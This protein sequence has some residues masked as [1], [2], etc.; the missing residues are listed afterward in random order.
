MHR[1]AAG[2]CASALPAVSTA[3]PVS[4]IQLPVAMVSSSPGRETSEF[5]HAIKAQLR[6]AMQYC[7]IVGPAGNIDT[8]TPPGELNSRQLRACS[9]E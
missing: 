1:T 4:V 9:H 2:A 7:P 8:L 6:A 3:N 5:A